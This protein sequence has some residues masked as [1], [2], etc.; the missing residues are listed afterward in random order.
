M[1]YFYSFFSSLIIYVHETLFKK[2]VLKKSDSRRRGMELDGS[3]YAEWCMNKNIQRADFTQ[4]ENLLLQVGCHYSPG[5]KKT[6][7]K[8][9]QLQQLLVLST[10]LWK[11]FCK[12]CEPFYS[13]KSQSLHDSRSNYYHQQKAHEPQKEKLLQEAG[14]GLVL[15][16]LDCS[17]EY[18]CPSD[19]KRYWG[20]GEVILSR[21]SFCRQVKNFVLMTNFL[22]FN[23]PLF[24]GKQPRADTAGSVLPNSTDQ[25]KIFYRTTITPSP[26][27]DVPQRSVW[28]HLSNLTDKK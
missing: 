20:G 10:D 8:M 3:V 21:K 13:K 25:G 18:P 6:T 7:L 22:A 28:K 12:M 23:M 16:C 26:I 11:P 14:E 24:T 2:E 19:V 9:L 4:Y 1:I 27:T 5:A 15:H 17:V